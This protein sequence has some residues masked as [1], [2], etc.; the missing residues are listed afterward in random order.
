M[1]EVRVV[2]TYGPLIP[3]DATGPRATVRGEAVAIEILPG[4]WLFALLNGGENVLGSA[5]GWSEAA[6]G[7]TYKPDG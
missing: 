6:Y 1:T 7:L 4:K 3:R 5:I 2:D